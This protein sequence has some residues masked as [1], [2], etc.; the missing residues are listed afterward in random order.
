V[1]R[2][3]TGAVLA[4]TLVHSPKL[5]TSPCGSYIGDSCSVAGSNGSFF[6]S[7]KTSFKPHVSQTADQRPEPSVLRIN[8]KCE[9]ECQIRE[10]KQLEEDRL[11][12]E[13]EDEEKLQKKIQD[14]QERMRKEYEAEQLKLKHKV[15]L[16]KERVY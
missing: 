15:N 13:K 16:D 14:D 10:R 2:A 9:L 5:G 8:Y 11:R 3:A 7:P 6:G 1:I 4:S 12:K